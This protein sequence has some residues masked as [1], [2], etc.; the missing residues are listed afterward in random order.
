MR[1]LEVIGLRAMG[2]GAPELGAV[3]LGVMGPWMVKDMVT[4]EETDSLLDMGE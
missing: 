2:L 4:T 1:G 3:E